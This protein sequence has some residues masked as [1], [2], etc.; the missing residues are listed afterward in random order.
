MCY[1]SN[2]YRTATSVACFSQYDVV[3][4]SMDESKQAVPLGIWKAESQ[5][6]KLK[7]GH[8]CMVRNQAEILLSMSNGDHLLAGFNYGNGDL[9]ISE[10]A[11]SI[12]ARPPMI[13]A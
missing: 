13:R 12:K 3:R 7:A 8:R 11:C 4:W 2:R 9:I 6:S 10:T 5:H 1:I